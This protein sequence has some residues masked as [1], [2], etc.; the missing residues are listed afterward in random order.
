MKKFTHTT[1]SQFGDSELPPIPKSTIE[2]KELLEYAV[3]E[4][5]AWLMDE[6]GWDNPG[7][8]TDRLAD[9]VNKIAYKSF[10]KWSKIKSK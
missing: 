1:Y 3:Y 5:M 10:D 9:E 6:L 7:D 8:I 2:Q 4:L